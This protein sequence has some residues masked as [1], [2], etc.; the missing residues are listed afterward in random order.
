[1]P[2][3]WKCFVSL[4]PELDVRSISVIALVDVRR[5]DR[6]ASW[7]KPVYS[8]NP[9][10]V[11]PSNAVTVKPRVDAPLLL[12]ICTSNKKSVKLKLGLIVIFRSPNESPV[13]GVMFANPLAKSRT[14]VDE[15]YAKIRKSPN[16]PVPVLPVPASRSMWVSPTAVQVL[17]GSKHTVN[18]DA[19]DTPDMTKPTAAQAML[20]FREVLIRVTPPGLQ[21]DIGK[22]LN[23]PR[24]GL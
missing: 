17:G 2:E 6:S 9:S 23:A 8:W 1:M 16:R 19:P 13:S 10:N 20:I 14:D 22:G 21:G 3:I 12:N 24:I 7:F 15:K 4:N 18:A 11:V 5:N